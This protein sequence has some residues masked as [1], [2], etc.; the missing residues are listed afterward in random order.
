M[1]QSKNN[2]NWLALTAFGTFIVLFSFFAGIIGSMFGNTLNLGS[3]FTSAS[4]SQ[5]VVVN[6]QSAIID[7]AE[8]SSPAVVSIIIS[9]D[10]PKYENFLNG[11]GWF[12]YPDRKQ[13]GTELQQIGSGSGFLITADGMI[14]TNRHVVSDTDATYTVIL[15]DG[16]QYDAKVLA[17]DTI[18]D[19][20]LIQIEASDLPFLNLGTSESLKIGQSVIAI[21]NSLGEF[22]NTVSSGIVSGLGRSI[23][24][25]DSG[26]NSSERL[27]NVIQTDASINPGNSGGPLLDI[28]GNVIGVNVAVAQNAEN[29]GFAIPITAVKPIVESVQATGKIVRPYLGV[30]YQMINKQLQEELKLP[31]D[32]GAL[33]SAGEGSDEVAVLENSPAAKAG[34]KAGDILLE[35]DGKELNSRNSLQTEIQKHK[36]GD[37]VSVKFQRDQDIQTVDVVLEEAGKN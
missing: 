7:V 6:E 16:K 12:S 28:T 10:L 11:N 33:I 29:I 8:K 17:R 20:A 23:T 25:S 2:T 9:K 15:N 36:V 31:V 5:Q 1:E 37:S 35:I 14:L 26:G 19:V 27:E 3:A 13:I 22:S 18:L 34:F 30:R 24:A 32:S 4:T 21:G